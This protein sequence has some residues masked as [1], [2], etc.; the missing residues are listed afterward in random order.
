MSYLVQ[1]HSIRFHGAHSDRQVWVCLCQLIS[2]SQQ[3]TYSRMDVTVRR[4]YT[5]QITTPQQSVCDH[6][7]LEGCTTARQL[8]Q[9]DEVSFTG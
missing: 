1:L 8:R 6:H 9:P 7:R 4:T 3:P 2:S 5:Q